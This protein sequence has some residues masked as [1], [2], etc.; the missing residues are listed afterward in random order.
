MYRCKF[1]TI[2]RYKQPVKEM[3]IKNMFYEI[4]PAEGIK[5][6]VPGNYIPDRLGIISMPTGNNYWRLKF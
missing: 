4:R 5:I 6:N 1:D 2:A 3:E